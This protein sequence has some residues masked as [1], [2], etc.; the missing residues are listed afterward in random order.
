MA[1]SL[2]EQSELILSPRDD[3]VAH[4][5]H[6]NLE[7]DARLMQLGKRYQ[8]QHSHHRGDRIYQTYTGTAR[9]AIWLF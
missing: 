3:K 2:N 8:L 5:V 6:V 1:C 7:V 4:A 9:Y